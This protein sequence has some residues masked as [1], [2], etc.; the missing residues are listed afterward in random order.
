MEKSRAYLKAWPEKQ[1]E[2]AQQQLFQSLLSRRIKGEPIAYIL[3]EKSFWDFSLKINSATL[4]PRPETELIIETICNQFTNKPLNILDLGTGSG[5]IAIA[6]AR[7]R[8]EFNIL[9]TDISTQ[10]IEVAKQ[11]AHLN[12]VK[13]I[14]FRQSHWFKEIHESFD[15]IVSNPPYIEENDPHLTQGDLRFEP[16]IALSSGLDGLDAIREIISKSK[17]RLRPN[18]LLLLEHGYQQ[19]A[20]IKQIFD[21]DGRYNNIYCL[22][23]LSGLDRVTVASTN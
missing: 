1:I 21:R 15:I 5:A 16:G 10:A 22:Q 19:A 17:D 11:N 9:A 12:Q 2:S 4:I 18:S 3:G 6:L 14:H 8:P 7:E 20:P 13:N 23:D